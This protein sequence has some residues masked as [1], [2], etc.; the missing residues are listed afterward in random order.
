M[1]SNTSQLAIEITD[2]VL[3]W[4]AQRRAPDDPALATE[5]ARARERCDLLWPVVLGFLAGTVAGALAYARF[6]LWCILAAIG[7]ASALALWARARA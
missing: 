6:D 2:L 5:H 3:T 1:T 7:L 4:R